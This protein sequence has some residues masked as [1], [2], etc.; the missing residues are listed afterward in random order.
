MPEEDDRVEPIL[1][2]ITPGRDDDITGAVLVG[3]G[4]HRRSRHRLFI[5]GKETRAGRDSN[6]PHRILTRVGKVPS[7]GRWSYKGWPRRGTF[8]DGRIHA[9]DS[10]G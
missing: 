10:P 2:E 1:G 6:Q 3:C 9:G 7:L 8:Q 5:D 4:N